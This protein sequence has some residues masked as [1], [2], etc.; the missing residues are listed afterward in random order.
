MAKLPDFIAPSSDGGLVVMH[1]KKLDRT[2]TLTGLVSEHTLA[3]ITS[4]KLRLAD[5]AV[6]D[7]NPPTLGEA[8]EAM[9]DKILSSSISSARKPAS[10]ESTTSSSPRV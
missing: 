6:T 8:L 5:G 2:T 7:L 3:E 4:A 10:S 9:R 1:D